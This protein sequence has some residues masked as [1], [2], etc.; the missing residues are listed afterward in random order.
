[1]LSRFASQ[2][3]VVNNGQYASLADLMLIKNAPAYRMSTC[4]SALWIVHK[5]AIL[6]V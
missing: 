1:M 4:M 2:L 6:K 3:I 5:H